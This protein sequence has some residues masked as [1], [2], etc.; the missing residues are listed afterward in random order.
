MQSLINALD[1]CS[2]GRE[3]MLLH[4]DD[5]WTQTIPCANPI[6]NLSS[7]T[8]PMAKVIVKF[9]ETNDSCDH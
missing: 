7:L 5:V 9:H 1:N 2:G 4:V 8:G 6:L 3:P